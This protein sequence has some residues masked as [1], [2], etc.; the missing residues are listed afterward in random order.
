[1]ARRRA[2]VKTATRGTSSVFAPVKGK[3]ARLGPETLKGLE[4]DA[5]HPHGGVVIIE[6]GD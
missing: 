2:K 6:A 1:M 5:R 4:T 3:G